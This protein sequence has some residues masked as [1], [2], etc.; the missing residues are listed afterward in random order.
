[1]PNS[2]SLDE[3]Q[4]ALLRRNRELQ[5]EYDRINASSY[6]GPDSQGQGGKNNALVSTRKQLEDNAAQSSLNRRINSRAKNLYGDTIDS[7]G[8]DTQNHVNALRGNLDKNVADADYANNIANRNIG[9][10]NLQ[11][12]MS[13]LN[14]SSAS[15]QNRIKSI[16][17]AASTNEKAHRD[18]LSS[19]GKSLSGR[20]TGLNSIVQEEIAGGLAKI[21]RPVQNQSRSIFDS[22]I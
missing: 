14:T 21:D 7:I 19:M 4:D 16:Y 17:G 12:G 9:R 5:I 22:F 6:T 2:Y 15:R 1:M 3:S 10:E 13:G 18:A 20:M 11:S 8:M